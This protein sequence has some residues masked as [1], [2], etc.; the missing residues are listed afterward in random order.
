MKFYFALLT[1]LLSAIAI[2]ASAA[3]G[4]HLLKTVP[5]PGDE[6]WDYCIVNSDARRVFFS[7]S[8]HVVVM[9]ADSGA[10][11]GMIEKTDGV[12]GIAIASDLGRGFTSNGRAASSTIFD[13]KTLAVIGEVKRLGDQ[14][15]GIS[16]DPATKRVFTSNRGGNSASAI[17]A[18]EGK[19]LST[20]D[21]GGRP[22]FS[23]ADGKGHVFIDLVD[24]D[25]VVQIDSKSL[26]ISNR[27]PTA[28]CKSPGTM[29]VDRKNSRLFVGCGNKL[30]AIM[31]SNTGKVITTLPIG[32]GRDAAMF[33]PGTGLIFSSNGDGT[34]T[35]IHQE[36]ADKYT[37]VENPKTEEGARTMAVDLKTHKIFFPVG[38]RGP[39]PPAT[40]ADPNPRG[41]VEP[42]SFHVLILGM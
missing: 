6:G 1:I 18:V 7:H 13:L 36:S 33:D 32:Q 11:V 10:V 42:G 25:I 23:G 17:D 9:N 38:K 34:V 16:Y 14:P 27:W 20:I 22:E 19:L 8:S 3:G 21:L 40:A 28:P 15:D 39:A 29:A 41:A 26:Q 31:D 2:T 4:Y 24:K 37:V 35:V 5:V 12:H 30:M